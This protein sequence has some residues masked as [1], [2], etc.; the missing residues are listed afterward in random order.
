MNAPPSLLVLPGI[1]LLV[2]GAEVLVRGAVRIAAAA[3]IP[4]IVIGLTIVAFGTSAPEFAV[5]LRAGLEGRGAVALGNVLGS[6]I[7]NVL[8]ILG[9]SALVRPLIVRERLVRFDVPVMIGASA[10][11]FLVGTGGSV[12]RGEG[13]FLLAL[14]LLQT[15]LLVRQGRS[16]RS[17]E[18]A[19]RPGRA[20]LPAAVGA[21]AAG[22]ALLVFGSRWLVDGATAIALSFGV[23]ER[24][25]G[26]TI[27]AWGTSLPELATSVVAAVRGER[28]IAV[29]NVVG[30]NVFNLLGVLGAAALLAPAGIPV[31]PSA[32][33]LDGPVMLAAAL[34]CFPVFLTGRSIAR[35]EGALFLAGFIGYLW[36]LGSG[37]GGTP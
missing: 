18:A 28:D 35:R 25:V 30:S 10:L 4:P 27:V 23:S 14:L 3:R 19:A 11:F 29:G 16:D 26:L 31:G 24:V 8:V 6:N 22:L 17:G 15:V 12:G 36:L 33:R 37:R 1:A 9:I 5:S 2:V 20:R 34:A 13:L 21:I 7:F 32:F